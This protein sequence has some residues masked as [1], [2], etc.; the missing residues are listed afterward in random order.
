[1]RSCA[2]KIKAPFSVEHGALQ[3]VKLK[4]LINPDGWFDFAHGTSVI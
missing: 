3:R 1:M 4:R 2:Q